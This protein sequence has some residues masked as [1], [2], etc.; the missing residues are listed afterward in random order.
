MADARMDS[1]VDYLSS[2]T[3]SLEFEDIPSEVVHQGKRL[4]V[5]TLGCALGG[6]T[7]EPSRIAR[8]IAR[9]I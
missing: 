2:Y 8:N 9:N 1:I 7:S 6:Y 5:D 3:A 4:W